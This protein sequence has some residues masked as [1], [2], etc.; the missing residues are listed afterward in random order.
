[1]SFKGILLDLDNTLYDYDTCHKPALGACVEFISYELNLPIDTVLGAY[2]EGRAQINKELH[3]QGASHSR[4]LYFQ[5]INEILGF[6]P[7]RSALKAER[8]YWEVFLNKMT[9][10]PGAEAFLSAVSAI[11]VAI[12]T[13]LTAQIQFRKLMHLNLDNRISAVVTSEESGAEKPDPR[14]FQLALQKLGLS[15]D[16]VCVVGDNWDKDILGGTGLGMRSF[17][18]NADGYNGPDKHH[19][20]A[21]A[22]DSFEQL[23]GLITRPD[24]G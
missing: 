3:G 6:K 5:R 19:E 10:R 11:P 9:Y 17:W 14:I 12:V 22:F 24:K 13:D 8:I 16:Q 2:K 7:C 1:M 23:T 4:L 21:V 20:L 18:L 15:A